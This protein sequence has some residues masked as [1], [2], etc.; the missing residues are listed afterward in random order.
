[1]LPYIPKMR[2]VVADTLQIE[3]D[4]VNIKATTEEGLGFTGAK[5]GISAQA[6]CLLEE[7]PDFVVA[8]SDVPP[9]GSCAGCGKKDRSG[10]N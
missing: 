7:L 5:E 6:I 9:C 4:R 10:S 3:L 2:V 1:M 8:S